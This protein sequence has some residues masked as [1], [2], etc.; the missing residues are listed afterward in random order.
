[1]ALDLGRGLHTSSGRVDLSAYDRYIG[2]WS[3]L[4]GPAV[5]AA[6]HVSASHHLLDVATGPGELATLALE[7][8][9]SAGRV[10][11]VDISTPMLRAARVRLEGPR[12]WPLTADGQSLPFRGATFDAVTCQL[13]LMFF[14]RPEQGVR[15]FRRVLRPGGRAAVCVI[16][17]APVWSILA[18]ALG[19]QLP[20]QRAL[21]S[22]S[23]SLGDDRALAEM[24]AR[25]G[26]R[27]VELTH[28]AREIRF[29]SFD[30]YWDPIEEGVGSLPQAYR[31]LPERER[32][33]VRERVQGRLKPFAARGGL[34]MGLEMLVCSG[35]A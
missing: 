31:A 18:E 15:E 24:F 5:L 20:D 3:R 14:A 4:F 27:E 11:A 35:G 34:E 22:L 6:A 9:A 12:F 16:S 29:D 26:F 2:R 19:E 32:H 30:E 8:M 23:F 17:S 28:E 7:R 25:A 21:L 1:M 10:T 33:A 13:G